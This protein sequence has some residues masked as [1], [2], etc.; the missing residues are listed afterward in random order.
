M[1][2]CWPLVAM[3][4]LCV[5]DISRVGCTAANLLCLVIIVLIGVCFTS[6]IVCSVMASV[7][8]KC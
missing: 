3:Y 2:L 5:G 8:T 1:Q 7:I 6:R 4:V